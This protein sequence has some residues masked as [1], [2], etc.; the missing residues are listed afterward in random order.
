MPYAKRKR[1]STGGYSKR[2]RSSA[3]SRPRRTR[4]LPLRQKTSIST[5]VGFP[6]MIK[7]VHR[8]Q[9]TVRLTNTSGALAF[10]RFRANGMFDP[11]QTGTGHQPLYFDQMTVLY[12]HY[13]II[14]AK[15]SVTFAS[16][17]SGPVTHCFVVTD[18]D[19]SSSTL[20]TT[21][22][23]QTQNKYKAMT[24]GN[25]VPKTIK[26]SYSAKKTFGGSIL[27]NNRLQGTGAVDPTEQSYFTIGVAPLD[28]I[29]NCI[30]DAIVLIEYIAVWTEMKDVLGS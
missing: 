11:N 23:E 28:G 7:M 27:A 12:N 8:Y 19:V 30:T 3:R 5:G 4:R 25:A 2:V 14:G 1:S 18:D 16:T 20:V 26:H 6:R 13:T 24:Y 29:S 17:G 15:I 9:E 10:Q 22:L 21:L